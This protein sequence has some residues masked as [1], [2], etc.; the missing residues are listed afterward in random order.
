MQT[1]DR[2]KRVRFRLSVGAVLIAGGAAVAYLVILR[3]ARLVRN[4]TG[5]RPNVLL[6]SVDTLRADHLSPYGSAW[7]T[8]TAERLAREGVTFDNVVSPAPIT[9]TAH[10]SLMTGAFPTDHGVHD[11]GSHLA[12]RHLTLAEIFSGAD[13]RTGAFVG[14]FVLDS[15][16][17]MAQGFDVYDDELG[18]AG[19][20]AAERRAEQVLDSALR[21]IRADADGPWFV[22]VHLFDPHAPYAPPVE[23]GQGSPEDPYRGEIAYV[24]DRLGRF[25]HAVHSLSPPENT[26]VALTADHG[27][28]RGEHGEDSHALFAYDS[29][30]R[31]PWILHWP[32][33]LEAGRRVRSRVRLVDVAPTLT[34]LARVSPASPFKGKSVLPLLEKGGDESAR[35]RP[36]YFESMAFHFNRGGAPLRGVYR[37]RY[38]YIELPIPELY[39]LDAD[40]GE[41]NNL[42]DDYRDLA[43]QMAAEVASFVSSEE[44]EL[45]D[46]RAELDAEGKRRLEALG[47]LHGATSVPVGSTSRPE[48]D[49][50][51]MLK[52]ARL[53]DEGVAARRVGEPARA[54]AIFRGILEERPDYAT[55]YIYGAQ[56]L[57][58]TGDVVGAAAL[59]SDAVEL[60]VRNNKILI[61]LGSL[62]G[63]LGRW[64]ESVGILEPLIDRGTAPPDRSVALAGLGISFA[65]LNRLEEARSAFQQSIRIDPSVARVHAN[66]GVLELSS[67]RWSAAERHFRDAIARDASNVQSWNGLGG[68]LRGQR[69]DEDAVVS[70]KRALSLDVANVDALYGVASTLAALGNYAE[71]RPY[72]ERFVSQASTHRYRAEMENALWFL[73]TAPGG[74][75]ADGLKPRRRVE[76]R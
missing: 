36:S 59:L 26:L 45:Q 14:A 7:P 67:Q 5:K 48:D 21:W 61:E 53:L 3:E 58:E 29:T 30:L 65:N 62:L 54:V 42:V 69:R 50:K 23:S 16:F 32:S 46:A 37:D 13:Y 1:N 72:F 8:P 12:E 35:D 73:D 41:R 11:N 27:E 44:T 10:A 70:W 57:R 28:G 2:F 76:D 43:Q 31:V 6:I 24:D 39:D 63:E 55:A 51:N 19:T 68:A 47:Y 38:K 40:P 66:L 18:A 33:V 56:V 25:L 22:F 4:E 71:A 60:E 15:R 74:P 52:Y 20:L 17:G 75:G 49:P 34:A 64:E 9:L